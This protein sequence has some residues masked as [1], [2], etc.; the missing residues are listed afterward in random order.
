MVRMS[1]SASSK[2]DSKF[3]VISD[4]DADEE[5]AHEDKSAAAATASDKQSKPASPRPSGT[6]LPPRKSSTGNKYYVFGPNHLLG[7]CIACGQH[8]AFSHVG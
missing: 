3:D 5:Q 8:V 1:S 2:A 4:T 6:P 7:P